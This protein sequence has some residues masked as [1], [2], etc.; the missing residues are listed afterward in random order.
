M[1]ARKL[2]SWT[3]LIDSWIVNIFSDINNKQ[4]HSTAFEKSVIAHLHTDFSQKVS[5]HH[6]TSTIFI[7]ML[8]NMLYKKMYNYVNFVKK[9]LRKKN[10]LVISQTILFT[11]W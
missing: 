10:G 6:K 5:V 4:I 7:E 3:L 11:V 8:F 9:I 1:S 2:I